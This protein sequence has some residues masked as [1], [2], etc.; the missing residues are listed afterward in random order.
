MYQTNCLQTGEN[1]LLLTV[2]VNIHDPSEPKKD[3]LFTEAKAILE[4][5]VSK[6]Q[7]FLGKVV[8]RLLKA[9]N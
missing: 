6:L 3:N 4:R 8:N 1:V 7:I 5:F 9:L 2:L